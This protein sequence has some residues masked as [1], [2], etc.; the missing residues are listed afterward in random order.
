[1]ARKPLTS[2]VIRAISSK[3]RDQLRVEM[4]GLD[5]ILEAKVISTKEWKEYL[6]IAKERDEVVAKMQKAAQEIEDKYSTPLFELRICSTLVNA[7]EKYN[8]VSYD[9][10]RDTLLVEEFLSDD[11]ETPEELINRIVLKIKNG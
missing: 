1:M 8:A 5:K 9:G 10:I 2:N 7:R 4:R 6:K 11:S 3:V